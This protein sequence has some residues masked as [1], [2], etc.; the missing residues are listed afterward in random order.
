MVEA[1][2]RSGVVYVPAVLQ[3]DSPANPDVVR[4]WRDSWHEIPACALKA[5]VCARL[6]EHCAGRGANFLS[7]FNEVVGGAASE[8]GHRVTHA[9][10]D[11]VSHGGGGGDQHQEQEQDQD[12][13]IAPSALDI[14]R[15]SGVDLDDQSVGI[16]GK[17]KATYAQINDVIRRLYEESSYEG[18]NNG[19]NGSVGQVDLKEDVKKRLALL[20]LTYDGDTLRKALDAQEHI[21][22]HGLR[23][24]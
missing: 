4:G 23:R 21:E 19:R 9:V 10:Q 11:F 8:T 16:Q 15:V 5:A 1:D 17:P 2:W 13:K 3:V 6:R 22:K 12:Q 24:R 18:G 14:Q 7:A 20:G